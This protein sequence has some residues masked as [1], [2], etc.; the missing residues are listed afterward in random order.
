MGFYSNF[1]EEDLIESYTNQVD[2][3]GKADNEILE[4]IL[5]R[6]SLED[7]LNKIKTKNLYQNEKNRLIREINGHYVNKRSKQECLSLI[8]STL[9]SGESIRLLVNIKY[10]QIHQ[11]VENLKVDSKTLMYSFV[12][13]IVASIISSVIIFTIL[14][15]FSFLSVFHFSLLIP[16]YIINYWVIRLITG[17]TR[18][19]LAVFI[20]SFIATLLNC[21]YF[22]F[23]INYS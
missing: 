11:N 6:S 7:F 10:D 17:K 14:Y 20:A 22:I 1:S 2:H 3:Q 8:S 12:G 5:R 21:L 16:A 9:L 4:E 23:L 18:V 15:Q 13:T 19:N